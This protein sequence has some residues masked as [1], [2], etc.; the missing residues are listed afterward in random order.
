MKTDSQL[1]KDVMA[2]LRWEPAVHSE[3]IGVE[4][5]DGV[6]TLVG[7]VSSYSEKWNAERAAQ[8]VTGVKA[9]AVEMDVKL[10]AI[11]VRTDADIA[12]AVQ[13]VLEWNSTLPVDSVK[14]MVENGYVSLSGTVHWQFQ[15]NSAEQAVCH[16]L[17]VKGVSNQIAIKPV[18]LLNTVK[19]DIETALKRRATSDAEQVHVAVNDAEVTLSGN[20]HSWFERDLAQDAA[21]GA[22]GVRKVVNNISITY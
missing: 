21:W 1:Q 7:H 15:R 12:R 17:G 13:N 6:V 20:V 10:S 2:E 22:A 4:V 19:A 5:K 11:G 3:Q 9:L 14:C 8:R 18:V 16:L